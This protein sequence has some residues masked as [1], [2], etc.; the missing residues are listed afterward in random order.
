MQLQ[1][2]WMWAGLS[3][4]EK[5]CWRSSPG[6]RTFQTPGNPPNSH[7]AFRCPSNVIPITELGYELPCWPS[8]SY[9]LAFLRFVQALREES[10]ID[11]Q[12]DGEGFVRIG[13]RHTLG[14]G[15]SGE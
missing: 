12:I 15:N 7:A 3:N 9:L 8:A 1:T 10:V 13:A 6:S 14:F 4:P 11:R 2:K 5:S